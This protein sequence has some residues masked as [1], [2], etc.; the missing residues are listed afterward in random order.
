MRYIALVVALLCALAAW[1][2][3]PHGSP[4]AQANPGCIRPAASGGSFLDAMDRLAEMLR[5][6][7]E[8]VG[9][10]VDVYQ[11]GGPYWQRVKAAID[12]AHAELHGGTTL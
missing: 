12:S 6:D 8:T 11:A 7:A 1:P 3:F 5:Q 10:L 4:E 9:K 2:G